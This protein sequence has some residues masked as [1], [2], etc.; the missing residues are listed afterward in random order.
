VKLALLILSLGAILMTSLVAIPWTQFPRALPLTSLSAILVFAAMFIA[1]RNDRAAAVAFVPLVMWST[2]SFVLLGKML[3]NARISHYGFYLAM[4]AT[5]VLAVVLVWL[6][7]RW[8]HSGA[9]RGAIF[10]TVATLLLAEGIAV[11]FGI[12]QGLYRMKTLEI[13]SNG[14]TIRTFG[15]A[16]DWRGEAIIEALRALEATPRGA[17]VA[18]IP[19][20]VM[21][22][23][24]SRREN[25]TPYTNLMV[26]ELL[27]FGESVIQRRFEMTPPDFILLAHKDTKEYAVPYFGSDPRNG[28]AMMDWIARH[29]TTVE[30][31]GRTPLHEGGYGIA[32]LKASSRP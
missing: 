17:T 31:I 29:Y 20:G 1:R 9:G 19:E 30:V 13:G 11:Y 28:Q 16:V 5:I 2:F 24:L 12:S 8:L 25:P 14:D 23:Y 4:P 15:P 6:V 3:L 27:T 26:P 32:I 7:P 22:N 21:I 10:R 18:V